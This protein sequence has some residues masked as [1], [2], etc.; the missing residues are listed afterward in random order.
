MVKKLFVVSALALG[1]A[2]LLPN[3]PHYHLNAADVPC[4]VRVAPTAPR[5]PTGVRIILG[6]FEP[7]LR[8]TT[9]FAGTVTNAYYESLASRSECLSAVSLRSQEQLDGLPT[10]N[11]DSLKKKPMLYDSVEDAAK[12]TIYAP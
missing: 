10:V 3:H 4:E 9:A 6:L 5:P 11:K 12:I 7:L 1:C 2:I 8:A